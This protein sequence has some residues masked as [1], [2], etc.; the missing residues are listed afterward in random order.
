MQ[1]SISG[2]I[3]Q[4]RRSISLNKLRNQLADKDEAE[5]FINESDHEKYNNLWEYCSLYLSKDV[6]TI[7][8]QIA[9]LIEYTLACQRFDFKRIATDTIIERLLKISENEG[10]DITKDA[11]RI[12]ARV[13][14]GGMRDAISLLELCAG[15]HTTINDELVFATVGSGN[16]ESA[17][18]IVEACGVG[19]FDAVYS[20]IDD[21][22]MKSGDLSVFWQEIIDCYRDIMVVKNSPRA[23]VY[24]DLTDSEFTALSKIA[25]TYSMP[26]LSYHASLLEGAMSDMQRAFNSKRSI[27]EITLTRMC[28]TRYSASPEALLVRI[29]ELEKTVK[30]M[31]M[32]IPVQAPSQENTQ[33]IDQAPVSE[34]RPTADAPSQV[35]IA[36]GKL[37]SYVEWETVIEKVSELRK[38]LAAGINQA[39][40][41]YDGGV[42][43]YLTLSDFFAKKISANETD[44]AILKGV[45][46]EIENK[47]AADIKIIIETTK[48]QNTNSSDDI[49][50]IFG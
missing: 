17:Y 39:K 21:I 22:V 35:P 13:S 37:R 41:L 16:R 27:A 4:V 11:A 46:V 1:Q 20:I 14:R 12:I 19:N 33:P 31:R 43:F 2:E 30:M 9:N 18:K 45:I 3:H 42:T 15:A 48:K 25:E 40:V 32:G 7:K 50:S 36:D 34:N 8:R 47:N 28:D 49:E 26:K 44:L 10:I 6:E 5:H 23:K 24:L 29:E 38:S